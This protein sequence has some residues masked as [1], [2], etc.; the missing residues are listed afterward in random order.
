MSIDNS[1]MSVR[2]RR[3]F[4]RALVVTATLAAAVVGLAPA[5]SAAPG[6]LVPWPR[7]DLGV[8]QSAPPHKC[9][10]ANDGATIVWDG[11]LWRC[12]FVLGGSPPW[13]WEPIRRA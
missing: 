3:V 9:G 5:A 12:E 13:Q 11:W 1:A 10:P 4:A 7:I 8:N 6:V 2:C